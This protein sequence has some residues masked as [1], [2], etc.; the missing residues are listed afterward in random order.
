MVGSGQDLDETRGWPAGNRGVEWLRL[1][2]PR[3]PARAGRRA[4]RLPGHLRHRRQGPRVVPNKVFQGAAAG[5]AVVTSDTAP[6]R[7]AL[8][9]AAVFVPA[10][11]RR[12]TRRR[13]ARPGRRPGR[14]SAAARAAPGP[15]PRP[16]HPGRRRRPL[17]EA[18]RPPCTPEEPHDTP[19]RSL[20]PL[21][22]TPGCAG[23]S[24]SGCCRSARPTCSRSAAARAASAPG[25]PSATRVPRRRAGRESRAVAAAAGRAGRRQGAQRRPVG[26]AGRHDVRP[27]LRLRGARAHRGRRRRAGRLASSWS[28]PA[29]GCCSRRRPGRTASGRRTRWSATSAATTA[30]HCASCSSARPGRRGCTRSSARRWASCSRPAATRSAAGWPPPAHSMADRTASSGPRF[31]PAARTTR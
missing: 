29:A 23:T 13:A 7:R 1:G 31:Q 15:G 3:R 22:R 24:W 6:Q 17:H 11:R 2:R 19:A 4:R 8:G 14:G 5:C 10:G 20:P 21:A 18:P 28:A 27:G 30:G 9:D 25:W 16:L 12:R 26:R